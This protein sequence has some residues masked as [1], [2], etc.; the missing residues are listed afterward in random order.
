MMPLDILLCLQKKLKKLKMDLKN[1]FCINI[2]FFLIL[3]I[4]SVYMITPSELPNAI[5]EIIERPQYYRS[6]WALNIFSINSNKSLTKLYSR[7]AE[8]YMVPASNNKVLTTS[9]A[10]LFFGPDYQFDTPIYGTQKDNNNNVKEV[11]FVGRGDSSLTS[12]DLNTIATSLKSNGIDSIDS[13]YY[14]NSYFPT[15]PDSWEYEDIVSDY[16]QTPSALVVNE[17][18]VTLTVSPS[19]VGS[20]INY[21]FSE[22]SD[23]SC[24]NVVNA[25]TTVS[26][27]SDVIEPVFVGYKF[28]LSDIFMKGQM[29]IGESPITLQLPAILTGNYF[30]CKMD[31]ALITNN[32]NITNSSKVVPCYNYVESDNKYSQ[33]YVH[34]S[35]KLSNLMNYTLQESVNLYAEMFQRQLGKNYNS[36]NNDNA[37]YD[38]ITAVSEILNSYGVNVTTFVQSD[39]SGL[40]RHNLVSTEALIQTLL[41]IKSSKYGEIY[42]TLLP[43]AGESGT[44][45]SRFI[46]TTAQGIL[47][48][49][50]GTESGVNALSGFIDKTSN[51]NEIVFSIIVNDSN[52]HAS[53]VRQGM[54]DI[55]VLL[56][57]L[58]TS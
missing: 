49:K 53:V 23:N 24:I 50:T 26:S 22:N 43:V 44:L 39:G 5:E 33:L 56:S 12:K 31:Y 8:Q 21:S 11:C 3:E 51:F 14:D 15:F 25:A 48:A 18:L 38:G 27:S 58:T 37:Y 52:Q 34:Q 13:I 10:M 20:H 46:G 35:D 9:A 36:S 57:Q 32:I 40:S 2:F 1:L 42:E 45:S 41:T 4:N 17:N 16:G 7:N 29:Y 19:K 28:G 30:M 47:H 54:D 55:C 6:D